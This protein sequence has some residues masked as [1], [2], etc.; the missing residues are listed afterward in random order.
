MTLWKTSQTSEGSSGSKSLIDVIH[1]TFSLPF[2]V[3]MME[4]LLHPCHKM[5]LEA[6]FDDLVK[7]IRCNQLMNVGTRKVVSKRLNFHKSGE[8]C[9]E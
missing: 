5:V 7:D 6:A 9:S 4:V 8:H 2:A 1:S 3:N